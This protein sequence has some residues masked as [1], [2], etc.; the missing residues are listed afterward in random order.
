MMLKFMA[1]LNV[2]NQAK[3]DGK[4]KGKQIGRKQGKILIFIIVPQVKEEMIKRE[5]CKI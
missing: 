4:S 2:S 1:K 3:Q 5:E